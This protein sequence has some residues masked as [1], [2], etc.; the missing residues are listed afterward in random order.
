MAKSNL[1]KKTLKKKILLCILHH[2]NQI[3]LNKILDKIQLNL[4]SQILIIN[5]GI[6]IFFKKKNYKLIKFINKKKK[7]HSIPINR[8]I[9]LNYA[10]KKKFD[11]L[12]F[13]DSDII[14]QKKLVDHH[15][16][17]F[18]KY[19]SIVAV[20]GPVIPSH[21][22]KKFNIWEFFDGHLSWFTS[23]DQNNSYFV[24]WP[25]HLPTCNL[26][27]N[28]LKLFKNK[29]KFNEE[30]QT[31]EDA[32]LF[33]QFRKKNLKVF[34]N[35]D[36]KVLHN[37]R[38]TFFNFIYHHLE[39][40]RHQYYNLFKIKK[41]IYKVFFMILYPAVYPIIV[42]LQTYFVIAK[43]CTK[44]IFYIFLI[45][46]FIFIFLAKSFVTYLESYRDFFK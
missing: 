17:T 44:N 30:I 21:S 36:C 22:F 9:A 5:D 13:L 31:G 33:N 27:L 12:L 37:D 18:I 3:N 40:G 7:L 46:F 26:S 10:K 1:S 42:L 28:V 2:N 35:K 8:N 19:P 16:Q 20:G 43:L 24:N 25:Y 14:P 38:K 45:P 39:W 23:I 11:I 6:N 4:I 32:D 41:K 15:L 29:V 34:F